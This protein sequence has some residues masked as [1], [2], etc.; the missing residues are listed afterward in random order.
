MKYNKQ[1]VISIIDDVIDC[2]KPVV[3]WDYFT[4]VRHNDSFADYWGARLKDIELKFPGRHGNM[5]TEEGVNAL[6]T[7]REEL[8][9]LE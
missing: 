5:I 4:N 7:I 8:I 1:M 3:E 2:N 9:R 6:R